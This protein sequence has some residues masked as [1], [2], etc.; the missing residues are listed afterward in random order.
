M[1]S[2]ESYEPPVLLVYQ[3]G[4]ELHF[5]GVSYFMLYVYE[6]ALTYRIHYLAL[7]LFGSF[8]QWL[9]FFIWIHW[10]HMSSTFSIRILT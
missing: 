10:Q 2:F 7:S 9:Q 3:I 1:G 5:E 8:E 6:Y 4:N